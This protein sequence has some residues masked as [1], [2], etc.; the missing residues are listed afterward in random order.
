MM[1]DNRKEREPPNLNLSL[2]TSGKIL[3]IMLLKQPRLLVQL[4][5]QLPATKAS[6]FRKNGQFLPLAR[7]LMLVLLLR[8]SLGL[9]A[10][11][12]SL[13]MKVLKKTKAG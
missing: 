8:K 5:H 4:A 12:R 3:T 2:V 1:K 10:V 11:Q 7:I 9:K 6:G 13:I